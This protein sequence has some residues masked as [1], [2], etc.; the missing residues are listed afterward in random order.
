MCQFLDLVW[1]MMGCDSPHESVPFPNSSITTKLRRVACLRAS[2]IC[3]TS[4]MK[5]DCVL[6]T[7][8]RVVILVK[9]L[10]VRPMTAASAG[11]K[12]PIW[13]MYTI[14]AICFW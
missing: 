2:A 5:A 7:V 8:S 4:I 14:N 13:A 6:E 11:T 10:S 3:C 12:L 9:I 1:A